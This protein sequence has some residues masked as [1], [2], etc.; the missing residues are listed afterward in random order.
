MGSG[1]GG[2]TVA[3]ELSDRGME[4]TLIE[5]GP[6]IECKD[7]F[8][9]Y[10]NVN[11][12]VEILRTSCLGGTTMVSAGN[13]VRCLEKELKQAGIALSEEAERELRITALPDSHFGGGTKKI[14]TAADELGFKVE[15]MPKFI[16]SEK[17]KLDG[18]CAY[19]C[20][21][22][23]KWSALNYVQE[24]ERKGVRII[25][26][27]AVDEVVVNGGKVKGVKS[28]EK[29]FS[30]D[31]VVLSA[32][33]L[34]TPRLLKKAGLP[35]TNQNLFVDTFI[36]VGG[37]VKRI[38][39]NKEIPMNALIKFEDFTLYPH[40]SKHLAKRMEEKGLKT[41]QEDILG[42][43][44]KIKDEAVGEVDEEIKK[45]VTNRDATIISEGASIAGSILEEAGANPS[46]FVSTL[47]RGAHP[48]G[49]AKIGTSVD[50]NLATAVSGL[51]VVDAS[52][53]PV[54]P[55]APPILTIVA[56]AKYAARIINSDVRYKTTIKNHDILQD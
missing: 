3:K 46:T 13:G 26:G 17:C 47:L 48:G 20:P 52:V 23:A 49:T 56:L 25:T 39:F 41:S 16:D 22:D 24:A 11:A 15:P 1:A 28:N 40:F 45:G 53:L 12:G 31:L 19:G 33:A 6:R 36:T 21:E 43:M 14:M 44:V 50:K 54:A 4:V 42:I 55:G 38:K 8:K 27:M 10:S 29:V 30:S 9:H 34:E 2:A 18:R 51:Y 35:V 5:K 32:G 37:I 7:A